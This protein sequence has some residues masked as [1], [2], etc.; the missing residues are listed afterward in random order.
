MGY[1]PVPSLSLSLND[2]TGYGDGRDVSKKGKS[3]GGSTV[4]WRGLHRLSLSILFQL[5]FRFPLFSTG[6][7]GGLCKNIGMLFVVV[8]WDI[9]VIAIAI[10]AKPL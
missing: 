3:G 7:G 6:F 10:K 8:V 1:D 9:P 5:A 2:A 4:C